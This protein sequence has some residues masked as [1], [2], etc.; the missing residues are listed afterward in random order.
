MV[1]TRLQ[2]CVTLAQT[3]T[4]GFL[5]VSV[6]TCVMERCPVN[7]AHPCCRKKGIV[8]NV[9]TLSCRSASTLFMTRAQECALSY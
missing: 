8:R 5:N 3:D 9:A 4:S 2:Q 7:T 6:I 1:M